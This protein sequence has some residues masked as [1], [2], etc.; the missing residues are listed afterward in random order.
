MRTWVA[1]GA[2]RVVTVATIRIRAHPDTMPTA[3]RQLAAGQSGGGGAEW[4]RCVVAADRAGG[5]GNPLRSAPFW[6]E[7]AGLTPGDGVRRGSGRA[8]G[9]EEAVA[10]TVA[11]AAQLAAGEAG[12]GRRGRAR[13]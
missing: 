1:R 10:A 9:G 4:W 5:G 8:G 11:W 3:G 12:R 6:P 13:R 7:L 2:S